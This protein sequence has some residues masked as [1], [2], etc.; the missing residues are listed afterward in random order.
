VTAAAPSADATREGPPTRRWP[1]QGLAP[2]SIDDADYFFGRDAWR[3]TITDYL[4]AYRLSILYGASGVGKSSV[5]R[6]GVAHE[7][8]REARASLER[9]GHAELVPVVFSSWTGEPSTGL[10]VAVRQSVA[11]LAPELAEDPPA[12]SLAAVLSAW[13]ERL[14]TTF[15]VMLDQFDEYF[16]YHRRDGG[17]SGFAAQLAEAVSRPDVPA[18]F[19]ISIREDT[20]AKLDRFEQSISGLWTNLLRIDHLGRDAAGE[21]IERPIAR[22]NEETGAAVEL[23]PGL[24]NAVL[25][26]AGVRQVSVDAVGRGALEEPDED[27]LVEAPYL[28]LVMTR[29]WEEES[30]RGSDVLRVSTLA[31]MGG[32]DQIVRSHFDSVMRSLPRR[33]RAVAARILQY[34]VTPSGTKIALPASALAKWSGSKEEKVVP[35]LQ[36]LAGGDHRI[37][38]TV[39]SPGKETAT[40]YE[41]FHDRLAPGILDWRARF[42]RRR[43]RNAA[44]AGIAAVVAGLGVL[45]GLSL[46]SRKDLQAQLRQ[47]RADFAAA[48]KAT[49]DRARKDPRFIAALPFHQGPVEVARFSSDG[50][51]ALTG[52]DD[53]TVIV[54][55]ARTGHR[56]RTLRVGSEVTRATFSPDDQLI[57]VETIDHWAGVWDSQG[58]R[59]RVPATSLLPSLA[60]SPDGRYILT[61]LEE[62]NV[63]LWNARTGKSAASFQDLHPPLY[64]GDI[65]DDG[66]LV[67]AGDERRAEVFDVGNRRAPVTYT[68]PRGPVYA[69]FIPGGHRLLTV[70]EGTAT[71]WDGQAQTAVPGAPTG[72]TSN[73]TYPSTLGDSTLY[74]GLIVLADNTRATISDRD[75]NVVAVLRGH[76]GPVTAARFSPD[77]RL[78]ATGADDSTARLWDARTGR[79]IAVFT[80]YNG[81]VYWVD[82]SPDG[83]RLLTASADGT[84]IVWKVPGTG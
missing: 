4:L 5:V 74:G 72:T 75:G 58:R 79:Q 53:G 65:S 31:S 59:F 34:L 25:D 9:D 52:S 39:P 3:E 67:V 20:L 48:E 62:G 78:V 42:F 7:L 47:E 17:P 38:R 13:G 30:R 18:N 2:Y 11:A 27:D 29:L 84:T 45:L 70:G 81:S 61:A 57:G 77:G 51:L 43:K 14:E 55:D 68:P 46:A 12:G 71:V 15:L 66:K 41:I 49:V 37:L 24:V 22:W 19:L 23:E 83:K 35:V 28:Q 69:A 54:S 44:L 73:V 80:P 26:E 32:A 82:F 1:Y 56:E 40:A 21:A 6:A 76:T 33:Q 36:S 10:Q 64:T 8:R 63:T 16:V 50:R 60:F